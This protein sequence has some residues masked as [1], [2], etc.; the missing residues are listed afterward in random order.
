MMRGATSS[1]QDLARQDCAAYSY[2]DAGVRR[3]AECLYATGGRDRLVEAWFLQSARNVGSGTTISGFK[4]A[5]A[6]TMKNSPTWG[7]NGMAFSSASNQAIDV[8]SSALDNT[9]SNCTMI[10]L[11]KHSGADAVGRNIYGNIANGADGLGMRL[12]WSATSNSSS[13]GFLVAGSSTS[14]NSLWDASKSW[15]VLAVSY[16]SAGDQRIF[17][18]GRLVLTTS[19]TITPG[20]SGRRWGIGGGIDSG[21]TPSTTFDGTIAFAAHISGAITDEATHQL[22]ADCLRRN[23]G[24]T[25]ATA[26]IVFEGDSNTAGIDRD[27]G[28]VQETADYHWTAQ[29]AKSS[30]WSVGSMYRIGSSSHSTADLT[31]GGPEDGD[32]NQYAEQA[33]RWSPKMTGMPGVLVLW[34][35]VNDR[36]EG[37]RPSAQTMLDR[38][39]AYLAAARADGFTTVVLT[40]VQTTNLPAFNSTIAAYNAL[41][42]ANPSIYDYLVDIDIPELRDDQTLYDGLHVTYAGHAW[43]AAK[44]N[45]TVTTPLTDPN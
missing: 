22:I 12:V 35:G 14:G 41:L 34:I 26:N 31:V 29:L 44:I 10:V 11:A 36:L 27:T 38:V 32:G 17:I 1:P 28:A 23:L 39:T 25:G 19:M 8:H 42:A 24:T 18:D 6:G 2:S 4:G 33:R 7:A 3:V 40:P 43:L 37:Q 21:G 45:S 20:T 16:D 15:T 9:I 5:I 13:A 30:N